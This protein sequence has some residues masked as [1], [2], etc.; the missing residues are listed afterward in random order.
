MA[1]QVA[2]VADRNER[3]IR[4]GQR[5]RILEQPVQEGEVRRLVPR[6]AALTVIVDAKGGKAERMVRAGDVEVIS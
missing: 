1:Q 4:E 6:Y 2:K 3:T 5:V